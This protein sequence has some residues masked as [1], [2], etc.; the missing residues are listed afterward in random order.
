VPPISS[1]RLPAALAPEM[2]WAGQHALTRPLSPVSKIIAL[3]RAACQ[4]FSSKRCLTRLRDSSRSE[5][6]TA[7]FKNRLSW[8]FLAAFNAG[9]AASRIFCSGVLVQS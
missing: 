8:R 2:D 6:S 5:F 7:S 3:D 1:E 9:P 4:A